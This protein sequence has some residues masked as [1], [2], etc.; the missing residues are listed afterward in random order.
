MIKNWSTFNK[1]NGKSFFFWVGHSNKQHKVKFDQQ[2][3]K[4]NPSQVRSQRSTL[5]SFD[6]TMTSHNV[7]EDMTKRR[8]TEQK[9]RNPKQN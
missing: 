1:P 6:H 9:K 7:D 2:K 3:N 4:L 8:L 5:V